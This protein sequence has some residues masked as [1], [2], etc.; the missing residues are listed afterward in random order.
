MTTG[1][2]NQIA[3]STDRAAPKGTARP[4]ATRAP[5]AG[6][7]RGHPP[8][9]APGAF[10]TS[11]DDRR[12]SGDDLTVRASSPGSCLPG[13][14]QEPPRIHGPTFP[15]IPSNEPKGPPSRSTPVSGTGIR[16]N[17]AAPRKTNHLA[18]LGAPG[19]APSTHGRSPN[20]AISGVRLDKPSRANHAFPTNQWRET[21]VYSS[22]GVTK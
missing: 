22:Q 8:N 7:R 5:P 20:R 11:K 9:D 2:I 15:H 12:L 16:V 4:A 14:S 6:G 21:T 18:T 1:R 10:S 17:T 3:T 13:R 19:A